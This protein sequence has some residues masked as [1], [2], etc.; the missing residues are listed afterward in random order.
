MMK[1]KEHYACFSCRKTFKRKLLC[2]IKNGYNQ[3]EE[4]A[5]CPECSQLMANMGKDFEAPKKREVKAWT[6]LQQLYRVG[7]TFHSCGCSG[8]GYIPKSKEELLLHLHK[9]KIHYEKQLSYWR[10]RIAPQTEAEKQRERSKNFDYLNQL[11][12][13]FNLSKDIKNE[14]AVTYWIN[15]ISIVKR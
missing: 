4:A 10:Q 9:I 5:K 2:D 6:H 3:K 13:N 7:I 1:Y 11:S 8:P 15:Q 12:G 14:A